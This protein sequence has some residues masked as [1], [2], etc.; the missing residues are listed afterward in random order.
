MT[1][2]SPGRCAAHASTPDLAYFWTADVSSCYTGKC[3]FGT[4]GPVY[5]V[6]CAEGV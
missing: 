5:L 3:L 1:E 6:R 2:M 4:S